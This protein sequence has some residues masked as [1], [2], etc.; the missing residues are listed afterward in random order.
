MTDLIVLSL[1][2]SVLN[3][4]TTSIVTALICLPFWSCK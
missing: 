3:M 1:Y 2:L 4:A